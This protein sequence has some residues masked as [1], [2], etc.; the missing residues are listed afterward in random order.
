MLFVLQK[1]MLDAGEFNTQSVC[2]ILS[3]G[4][5]AKVHG[6]GILGIREL[7]MKEA[8]RFK[9]LAYKR[10]NINLVPVGSLEFT[11][12][13]LK[14]VYGVDKLNTIG[15]PKA[16]GEVDSIM[17]RK[18]MVEYGK[19][20]MDKL[21]GEHRIREASIDAVSVAANFYNGKGYLREYESSPVIFNINPEKIYEVAETVRLCAEHRVYV[22]RGKVEANVQYAGRFGVDLDMDIVNEAIRIYDAL[23][24]GAKSYAMD[25]VVSPR[26]TSLTGIKTFCEIGI[27]SMVIGNSL[28]YAIADG[29]KYFI[30]EN[31]PVETYGNGRFSD[32]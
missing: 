28:L 12:K 25:F 13:F 15:V 11:E 3:K 5:Y 21:R 24:S 23:P 1:E 18:Y 2:N 16:L 22:V 19:N 30:E 29:V 4:E 17:N 27:H 14:L 32:E 20:F 31:V 7:T 26:G 8:E 9:K 6:Y 10:N